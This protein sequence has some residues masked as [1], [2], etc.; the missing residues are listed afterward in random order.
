MNSTPQSG[1]S[2]AT[3][4]GS[5]VEALFVKALK[6]TGA[7]EEELRGAGINIHR[8]ETQYPGETF[9]TGIEIARRH[10]FAKLPTPD[11]ERRLGRLFVQGFLDT[12]IG[13]VVG[14]TLPMLG[15]GRLADRIPRLLSSGGEMEARVEKLSDTSRR[16]TF[17]RMSSPANFM[18][19]LLEEGLGRSGTPVQARVLEEQAAS[20]VMQLSW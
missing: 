13:K 20:Y 8:L 7:F 2:R 16:V 14:V 19:G 12:L 10:R 5:V 6:P 9:N 1:S 3:V 4:S 17:R 11:G 18:A 15:A